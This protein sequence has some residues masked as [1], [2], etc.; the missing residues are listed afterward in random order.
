[1]NLLNV[2]IEQ[3]QSTGKTDQF[4]KKWVSPEWI[5]LQ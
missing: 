5:R 3:M 1:V 2:F 4:I